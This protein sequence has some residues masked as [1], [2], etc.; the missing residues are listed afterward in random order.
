MTQPEAQPDQPATA[1]LLVG[2][3]V[4]D[5]EED[6]AEAPDGTNDGRSE[7]ILQ[8][9]EQYGGDEAGLILEEVAVRA[10][11]AVE[12]V[13]G[14]GEGPVGA[15]DGELVGV[16]DAGGLAEVCDTS[17]VPEGEPE[18]RGGHEDDVAVVGISL[19]LPFDVLYARLL[20]VF[21][22]DGDGE[23][24]CKGAHCDGEGGSG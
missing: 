18:G 23:G 19:G 5:G 9:G 1:V 6:P 3:R 8:A 17:T 10:L 20:P 24:V 21:A 16:C 7:G 14:G 4:A 13:L 12:D 11:G 22:G 15:L 2:A